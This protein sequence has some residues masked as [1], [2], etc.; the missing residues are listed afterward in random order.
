MGKISNAN[1]LV[2]SL[3]FRASCGYG[4][5]LLD[6]VSCS[7]S[8]TVN[9]FSLQPSLSCLIGIVR[10]CKSTHL[11]GNEGRS[12]H[13]N[14]STYLLLVLLFLKDTICLAL[15]YDMLKLLF[16]SV[17]NVLPK[18]KVPMEVEIQDIFSHITFMVGVLSVW[19]STI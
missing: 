1:Y 17:T 5:W 8:S 13:L 9:S 14:S 10:T 6:H 2:V 19:P 12:I 7:F 11:L 3:E 18:E 16:I 4:P 15:W